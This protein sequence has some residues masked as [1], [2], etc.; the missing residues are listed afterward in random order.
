MLGEIT[1]P[2]IDND[3]YVLAVTQKFVI[4][5]NSY[6]GILIFNKN[7]E[8]IDVYE[9]CSDLMIYQVYSDYNTDTIVIHD[10]E[11]G[12]MYIIYLRDKKQ[13]VI[14]DQ[15]LPY[16]EFC[17]FEEN[18]FLLRRLDYMYKFSLLTGEVIEKKFQKEKIIANNQDEYIIELDEETLIYKN[19]EMKI[20]LS[21]S[22]VTTSIDV[23]NRYI[24]LYDETYLELFYLDKI[25]GKYTVNQ[26]MELR[27]AV[28]DRD[29]IYFILNKKND[30]TENVI[31]KMTIDEVRK[32]SK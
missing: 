1:V 25:I 29:C 16:T 14:K 17:Y 32:N 8:K 18:S 2:I 27:K 12:T 20:V 26:K 3:I 9:I 23:K 21:F 5:N 11:S 10:A 31:H 22:E 30:T 13:I 4:V 19:K 7:L 6:E 28:I 24:I 15:F